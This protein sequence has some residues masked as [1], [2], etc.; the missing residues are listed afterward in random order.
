MSAL[1][2]YARDFSE[3]SGPAS[4]FVEDLLARGSFGEPLRRAANAAPIL[5]A[6]FSLS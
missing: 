1:N 5:R 4:R 6:Q 3:L 2:H